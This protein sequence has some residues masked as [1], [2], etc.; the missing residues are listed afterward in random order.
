MQSAAPLQAFVDRLTARNFDELVRVFAPAAA[1]RFL[2]PRRVDEAVGSN[3][4]ARRF[5]GWFGS[6]ENFTVL[7]QD[8]QPLGDRWL[9]RWRFRLSRDG[10][11]IEVIEQLAFADLGPAGIQHLDLLCSGFVPDPA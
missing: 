9:M 7:S 10:S 1:A 8:V 3:A 5:E 11:A 6:A 2:L 4:I